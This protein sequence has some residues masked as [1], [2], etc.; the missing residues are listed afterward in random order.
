MHASAVHDSRRALH[1]PAAMLLTA[2]VRHDML[3]LRAVV[4]LPRAHVH[5]AV[6][7]LHVQQAMRCQLLVGF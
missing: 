2:S 6:Y 7:G 1:L 4:A 5:W 3:H